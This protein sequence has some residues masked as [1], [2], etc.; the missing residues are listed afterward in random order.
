M[1]INYE[2]N[3]LDK[4]TL[5]ILYIFIKNSTYPE[6]LKEEN[7]IYSYTPFSIYIKHFL[8]WKRISIPLF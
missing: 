8:H 5:T 4:S 6:K 7:S 1:L 3:I 2:L